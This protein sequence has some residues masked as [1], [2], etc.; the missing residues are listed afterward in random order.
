MSWENA[1][2]EISTGNESWNELE[3]LLRKVPWLNDAMT[4]PPTPM[5]HRE[6]PWRDFPLLSN[7]ASSTVA[8]AERG[9]FPRGRRAG[10]LHLYARA[11]HDPSAAVGLLG[12][13]T[14]EL[15][16]ICR[17]L[18]RQGTEAGD[19]EGDVVAIAW[20]VVSGRRRRPQR[21]SPRRLADAIWNEVRRESGLRRR[22]QLKVSPWPEYLDPPAS[23][24]DHLDRWP[25]LL[26]AA[27]A[28]GVLTPRQVVVVAETRMEG[29]SMHEMAKRLGRPVG[30]LYKERQRAEESLRAFALSYDWS[31]S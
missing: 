21:P 3:N 9:G 12:L 2:E 8:L 6:G 24:T 23:G 22:R 30:A 19:A 10:L 16:S 26:A 1:S 4:T 28:A 5:D 14:P 18:V 31:S 29:R 17:H 27:V 11:R 15:S 13:L 7:L 25:G 20:E